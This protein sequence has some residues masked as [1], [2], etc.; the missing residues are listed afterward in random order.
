M[1]MGN[2]KAR[3]LF[4]RLVRRM[5]MGET[6]AKVRFENDRDMALHEE[7]RLSKR[8]IRKAAVEAAI[9]TGAV[10]MLLPRDL[11]EALGLKF[12]GKTVV[13]LAD[14]SKIEL[15][16][17]GPVRLTIAGRTWNTDCLVGPPGCEPLIGQLILERLDLIVDPTR[18]TVTV[19]P[20]SP[21]L[22]TLNLKSLSRRETASS[23]AAPA[24]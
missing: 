1:L 10:M 8:K 5:S 6:R 4:E 9:D 20:E 7:G 24:P 13:T 16:Q 23:A 17:A 19:R 22:P 2:T 14:D 21:W 12:L 15:E 18:R 11:V 3:E